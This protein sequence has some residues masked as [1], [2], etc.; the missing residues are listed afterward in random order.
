MTI[1]LEDLWL[2]HFGEVAQ[3]SQN[4]CGACQRPVVRQNYL[5]GEPPFLIIQIE[6]AVA[7]RLGG[8]DTNIKIHTSV[9]FPEKL[10]FM[11]TG[12]YALCG[13]VLHEGIG[14]SSGHYTAYCRT[15]ELGGSAAS[16]QK[17]YCQFDCLSPG[18]ARKCSWAKLATPKTRKEVYILMYARVTLTNPENSTVACVAGSFE[19]PYVRGTESQTLLDS[20]RLPTDSDG[21]VNVLPMSPTVC[22]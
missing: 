21:E 11:R 16:G 9:E 7:C 17:D 6:R 8:V 18:R 5:E 4:P 13:V 1:S 15:A 14:L 12:S 22:V 10:S 19:T 20:C 3:D 2:Y